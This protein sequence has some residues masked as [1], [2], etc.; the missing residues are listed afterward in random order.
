MS[1]KH[2]GGKITICERMRPA[3]ERDALY[4]R[5]PEGERMKNADSAVRGRGDGEKRRRGEGET[6]RATAD[7]VVVS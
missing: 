6:R 5:I 7:E 4:H 1:R 3:G 2:R